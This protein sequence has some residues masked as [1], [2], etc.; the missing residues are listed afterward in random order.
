MPGPSPHL[1]PDFPLR[2]SGVQNAA[3]RLGYGRAGFAALLIPI[4][5]LLVLALVCTSNAKPGNA[6][7]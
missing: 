7:A 3:I 2:K 4:L 6:F 5:L 1:S